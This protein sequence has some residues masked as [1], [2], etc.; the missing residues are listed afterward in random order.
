VYGYA[1]A[2]QCKPNQFATGRNLA[3]LKRLPD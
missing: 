1:R 2:W 3:Y